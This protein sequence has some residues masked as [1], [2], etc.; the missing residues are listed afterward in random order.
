MSDT[1]ISLDDDR[2]NPGLNTVCIGIGNQ[3]GGV[4]KT[5]M[6][7][8]LACALGELGRRVLVIDL[9]VNAGATKH[10]GISSEAFLG[11]F[12][13][14]AEG[15][16]PLDVVITEDDDE[17]S[18]PENVHVICGSRKL[19]ELEARLRDKNSKFASLNDRLKPVLEQLNGHYDYVLVDTP[20][21]APL[22]IILTY[23]AADYFLLVA[24]PEGLA[25]EGLAEAISD[26]NEAREYG[27]SNVRVLG[28]VLG[29]IDR[30]TR[31]SRELI[32]YVENE[33]KDDFIKPSIPR[34]TI[35]PTAQT[36]H[37]TIFETDPKHAVTELYRELAINVERRLA[38]IDERKR[39]ALA[40]P[41]EHLPAPAEPTFAE[42]VTEA[43]EN[44]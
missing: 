4:G 28:V 42:P 32:A 10:F 21:S 17:V 37:K 22:P 8:Q 15:E 14:L 44:G 19:E 18:L 39:L 35:I 31:L 25:I 12:E 23:T 29:A 36:L 34:S 2:P 24:I 11:S 9:D 20:P 33:F 13:M 40:P 16:H 26:I 7:V 43:I 30:R 6:T 3:K 1:I 27:G 5:S 38:D 41:Q